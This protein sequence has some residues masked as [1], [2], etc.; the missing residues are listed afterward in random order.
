M[1]VPGLIVLLVATLAGCSGGGGVAPSAVVPGAPPTTG[2]SV[3]V[4][5]H[6][7]ATVTG[8]SLPHVA[9][10]LGGSQVSADAAGAFAFT[11]SGTHPR[12][13]RLAISG[14]T[15]LSRTS[16]IQT[17]TSREITIDAIALDSGFDLEYYRKI[18]RNATDAP[19]TLRSL[20]RWTQA[21]RVYLRTVDQAGEPIDAATLQSTEAALTDDAA[22]WTG[23]RFGVMEV[24]RG[25]ETR[26][27]QSGWI[28]V[29]W[30]NPANPG[31]NCGRAQVGVDGGWIE[32][33]YRNQACACGGSRVGS[34]IVRH[35]LGHALVLFHTNEPGDL[36]Q[37]TLDRAMACDGHATASERFH[38][39]IAYSRPVGNTDPDNDPTATVQRHA[40]GTIVIED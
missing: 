29:K 10:E 14:P 15:I 3:T 7:V 37:S 38:A 31:N 34:G 9:I 17:S 23:G 4:Q 20:Q 22:A 40:G 36:M 24:V 6:V 26:E 32:L 11:W 39:A 33:N 28:T 5:G 18:V 25:T 12:S 21:P 27:G 2:E 19:G 35:E 1:R 8:E 16:T 30:P 13:S